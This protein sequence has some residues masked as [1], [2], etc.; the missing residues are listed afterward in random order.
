MATRG[1]GGR[2]KPPKA[3]TRPKVTDETPERQVMTGLAKLG[4]ALKSSAWRAAGP[5]GL[6]PTQAQILALLRAE[7]APMR[8]SAIAD[9][10]GVTPPTASDAVSALVTKRLV[11]KA[12]ARQD[13][14]AIG[15]RL[16]AAGRRLADEAAGWPDALMNVVADLTPAEQGALLRGLVKLIRGLQVRG[17]IPVARMC[18]TCRYFR[19][20]AHPDPDAP[21]HCEFVDAPLGDRTLRLECGD[22]EMAEP[23]A[24]DEKWAR[25]AQA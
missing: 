21:H 14:R 1:T 20:R 11:I 12:R 16:T 3:V 23:N 2:A 15:V 17:E 24:Q 6:T 25:F 4:L 19:A 13:A 9:G 7:D 8:L 22:H 10:L 18:V 5:R